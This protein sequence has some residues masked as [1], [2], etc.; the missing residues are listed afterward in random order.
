MANAFV[1][2]LKS[3][4]LGSGNLR[5]YQH[6]SRLYLTNYYELTP[7]AGWIY[8]VEFVINP[9]VTK[10]LSVIFRSPS[11]KGFQSKE[12]DDFLGWYEK[13]KNRIGLLAK[14]VG[15]PKFNIATETLNQ[16]NRKAVI[17]KSIS[18][19]PI[20]IVFHD[21]MANVTTNLWKSYYQYYYGDSIGAQSADSTF[22]AI[23]KY[24][25]TK[26]QQ[27][28][29]TQDNRYGLN[30]EQTEPFFISIDVYQLYQQKYT[31]FKIVNPLIKDWKHDDLDQT[32][33]SRL[34]TNSMTLDYETVIYDTDNK[35]IKNNDGEDTV[36][37]VNEY[38]DKTPSPL[39]IG[40]Q[41]TVSILGQGGIINGARSIF[42]ALGKPGM[43][44]LG[45]LQTALQAG[46]LIR[47][48]SNI[49]LD[50]LIEEGSGVFSSVLSG[51]E[52]GGK[53]S[54][55][56]SGALQG[57][58]NAVNPAGL[59]IPLGSQST[60]GQTSATPVQTGRPGP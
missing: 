39:S 6:A 37:F 13:N 24:Q 35:P 52:A 9:R 3:A 29:D 40:G 33:G 25:N 5:D 2:F 10:D 48:A 60:N 7:K 43:S 55:I 23:P 26:Y 20:S 57:L 32:Q 1:N 44:P 34:L 16:Y 30:N 27:F 12:K 15:M 38:Y 17:Q 22:T 41:G 54:N 28:N 59:N 19:Q 56:V 58:N 4:A 46:N 8:Y 36:G 53:E 11:K 31:S 14:S 45:L 42:G 47:N 50:G 51:I 49:S 21:D 18:Y